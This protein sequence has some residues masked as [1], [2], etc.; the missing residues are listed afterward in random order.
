MIRSDV[1]YPSLKRRLKILSTYPASTEIQYFPIKHHVRKEKET[2]NKL[3]HLKDS[4]LSKE[5]KV[6]NN[7]F[8]YMINEFSFNLPNLDDN[9]VVLLGK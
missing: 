2:E 6:S 9:N 4:I 3:L 7:S 1:T 8:N 5:D